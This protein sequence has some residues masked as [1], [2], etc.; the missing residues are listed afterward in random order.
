M[1]LSDYRS[2]LVTGGTGSFDKAFV[3]R[4]LNDFPNIE[5]LVVFSRDELKQF[6]MSQEFGKAQY[7]GIRYFIGDVRDQDRLRRALEGI[8]AV[9]HAAALKQVRLPSITRSSVSRPISWVHRTLWKH[10]WKAT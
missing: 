2:L 3:K 9:V 4:V 1:S 7:D 10:A 8:E 5:R 6:D